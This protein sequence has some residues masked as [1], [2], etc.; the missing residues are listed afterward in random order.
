VPYSLGK[1]THKSAYFQTLSHVLWLILPR[2]R[3]MFKENSFSAY[4]P[5]P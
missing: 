5:A 3:S 1:S 4:V 2:P